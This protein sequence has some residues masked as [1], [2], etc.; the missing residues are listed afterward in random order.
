MGDTRS[1]RDTLHVASFHHGA[2]PHAVLM[3]ERSADN[4]TDDFKI[5]MRMRAETFATLHPVFVDYSQAPK[6]DVLR[7]VIIGKRKRVIAVGPAVVGVAAF[8]GLAN[9][10]HDR[11]SAL[12]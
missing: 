12:Q 11:M 9:C 8:I 4:V 7:V 5:I 10:N 1:R 2:V 3:F 6:P